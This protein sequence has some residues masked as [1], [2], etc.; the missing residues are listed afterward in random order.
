M[1]VFDIF[2]KRQ[3]K[4]RGEMPDVYSY[5]EL[6]EALRVQV[7]HIFMEVIGTKAQFMSGDSIHGPR[8]PNVV[9]SYTV[10]HNILCREYGVFQ[11]SSR[12]NAIDS[13]GSGTDW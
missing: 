12:K 11:L 2:S 10:I 8:Y 1:N 3:K 9:K 13:P 5:D 6:P 4:L 7:I